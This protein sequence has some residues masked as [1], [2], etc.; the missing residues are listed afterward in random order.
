VA[1]GDEILTS[2]FDA[3][4]IGSRSPFLIEFKVI[5]IGRS[6]FAMQGSAP[7]PISNMQATAATVC[8]RYRGNTRRIGFPPQT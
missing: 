7:R 4:V 3:D 1:F 6:F 8:F 2:A 5:V